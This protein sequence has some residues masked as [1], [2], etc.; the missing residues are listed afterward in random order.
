M[1]SPVVLNEDQVQGFIDYII[2]KDEVS[3]DF[4]KYLTFE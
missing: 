2:Q 3:L 1:N 4:I